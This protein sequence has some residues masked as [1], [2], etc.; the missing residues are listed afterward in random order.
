MVSF[1]LHVITS[2]Y[3]DLRQSLCINLAQK[4]S[5]RTRLLLSHLILF[6]LFAFPFA[7]SVDKI[8]FPEGMQTVNFYGC[9]GLTGKAEVKG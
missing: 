4:A 6:P 8:V 1:Q 5:S 3:T 9:T 7:G 2:S